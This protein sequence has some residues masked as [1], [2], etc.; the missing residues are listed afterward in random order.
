MIGP[1]PL[2]GRS[3]ELELFGE[4]LAEG[5]RSAMVLTGRAGVGKSRLASECREVAETRGMAAATVKASATARSLPLG[6]LAPLIPSVEGPGL[7]PTDMLR[8]AMDAVLALGRGRPLLLVVDDAHLLDDASAALVHHLAASRAAFVVATVRSDAP[9]P[10]LVVALW[11]DELA[12]RVEVSPLE[13]ES[14]ETLVTA[15]LGGPV[16]VAT[17]RQ[18]GERSGGNP[19]YLRELVRAGLESGALHG[20][21]GIWR[22]AGPLT[23]SDRLVE[24]IEARLGTETVSGPANRQMPSSPS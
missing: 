8:R 14:V 20:E 9:A 24:L 23:V 19:L 11:K 16:S 21:D 7:E 2:V 13:P 1:W 22:L 3:R 18:L 5:P 10:E 15:A 6:A 12:E 4:V 17:L